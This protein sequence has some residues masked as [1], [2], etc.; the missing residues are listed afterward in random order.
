MSASHSTHDRFINDPREIKDSPEQW[1]ASI[2]WMTAIVALSI[3][4]AF[5]LGFG[6]LAV[7][8]LAPMLASVAGLAGLLG[9]WV[10]SITYVLAIPEFVRRGI[11]IILQAS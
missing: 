8:V 9:I 3:L 11:V 1:P 4:G 5:F 7:L 6:I 10:A 2:Q